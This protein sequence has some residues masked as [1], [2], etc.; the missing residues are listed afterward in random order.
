MLIY[1]KKHYSNHESF[2]D[3]LACGSNAE[4]SRCAPCKQHCVGKTNRGFSA[5]SPWLSTTGLSMHWWIRSKRWKMCWTEQLRRRRLQGHTLSLMVFSQDFFNKLVPSVTCNFAYL[6]VNR[7]IANNRWYSPNR[8]SGLP[9]R[10][11]SSEDLKR[12]FFHCGLRRGS[13]PWG[14]SS[15]LSSDWLS[16]LRLLSDYRREGKSRVR[17]KWFC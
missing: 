4:F 1:K 11:C 8:E 16:R 7:A 17:P 14:R 5:L 13:R 15:S 9:S 6:R 2:V 10:L 12:P 3:V